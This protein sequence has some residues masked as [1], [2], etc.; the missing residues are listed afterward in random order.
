M[1]QAP[2]RFVPLGPLTKALGLAGTFGVPGL[3]RFSLMNGRVWSVKLQYIMLAKQ[4]KI[5]F[6]D[7]EDRN[8]YRFMM[9][10][11]LNLGRNATVRYL[12]HKS[13]EGES[14]RTNSCSSL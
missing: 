11:D 4:R 7:E 1:S 3:C 8:L 9:E 10:S 14:S 12:E 6:K 5:L 13:H 2:R